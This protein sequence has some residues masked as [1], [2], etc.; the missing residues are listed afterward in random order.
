M[1]APLLLIEEINLLR[2]AYANISAESS[3]QN[4]L[5]MKFIVNSNILIRIPFGIIYLLVFPIPLWN[6]FFSNSSYDL[7]KSFNAI[8]MIW[9]IPVICLSF[10]EVYKN[11]INRVPSKIFLI[12][13]VFLF[14]VAISLTSMETRHLGNFLIPFLVLATVVDVK[15]DINRIILNKINTLFFSSIF[16]VHLLWLTLKIF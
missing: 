5:G 8:F 14:T 13:V 4:S 11:K 3:N 15:T 7:L 6:G 1:A 2:S 10:Y 12:L 16:I 9:I